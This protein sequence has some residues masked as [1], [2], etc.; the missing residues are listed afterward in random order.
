VQQ[1]P[2]M[3][4]MMELVDSDSGVAMTQIPLQRVWGGALGYKK[5]LGSVVS[6]DAEIYGKYYDQEPRYHLNAD[7][8]SRD[9]II[10]PNKL[11]HRKA[12]GVEVHVQK[13]RQDRFFYEVAYSFALSEQEYDN[14][15]WYTADDNLRNSCHLI[16]G[17]RFLKSHAVST[18]LDVSEGRPYARIDTAQ[19]LASYQTRYQV[20]NGWNTDRRDPVFNLSVRYSHNS[21]FGWGRVESYMEIINLLNRTYVVEESYDIGKGPDYGSIEDFRSRGFFFVGGVAFNF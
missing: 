21:N 14:G 10:D 15:Q 11:W 16:L 8:G 5:A 13:N 4:T 9:I 18:R 19:S 12:G 17:S 1:F 6:L 20:G 3:F 2:E 7:S